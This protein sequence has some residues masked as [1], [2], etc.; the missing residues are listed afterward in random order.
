MNNTLEYSV[1][2]IY[3]ILLIVI[4]LIFRSFNRNVSDYFRGGSRG[5]WWLVGVSSFIAGISAYTFT[6]AAGAVYDA[7]WS[8]LVIYI[9]GAS[10]FMINYFYF[11]SRF[12]QLRKTTGQE[13]I[14][15]RFNQSTEQLYAWISFPSGILGSAMLLYSLAIFISAIFGFNIQLLIIAVGVVVICY[16]IIGG[17]WAIMAT[18][19][20]QCLIVMGLSLLVGIL[21][22]M[23]LNGFSGLLAHIDN[24]GL[25]AD[26]AI[27]NSPERFK[28]SFTYFWAGAMFLNISLA[29]NSLGAASRYFS[30]KDGKEAKK[31]ALLSCVLM[32]GGC[33]IWFLPPMT[34][35]IL[36]SDTVVKMTQLS[37]PKEAAFA[38]TCMKLLP[39]GMIG[40]MAV[41]MFAASISSLDTG[42]NGCS[43]VF[44]MNIYPVLAKL[45][46][47]RKLSESTMLKLSRLFTFLFGMLCIVVA[48]LFS[49]KS[50]LSLFDLMLMIF[51]LIGTPM[52]VPLLWGMIIRRCPQ[53]AAL[54]SII[55]GFSVSTIAF[56]SPDLFD[57]Q[58]SF[59]WQITGVYLGGS[60]GFLISL[61]WVGRNS[62]EYDRQVDDFFELMNKPVDFEKEIG[63]ANDNRQLKIIGVVSMVVGLL[64]ALLAIPA[65]NT[66]GVAC[67]LFLTLFMLSC[68]GLMYYVGTREKKVKSNITKK[69]LR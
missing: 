35:R 43:S 61:F 2:G 48:L 26:Y 11:A 31:A 40:L 28:G 36:Y 37:N 5:T 51:A 25:T 15:D 60:L 46:K 8:V 52:T 30:V 10:G 17:R 4:G 59:A 54:S 6:G 14:R 24:C 68:G 69:V 39:P 16:S 55:C 3:L 19:F 44:I 21:C 7:G 53:W 32:L 9:G 18:D 63:K 33:I 23:K 65:K 64:I 49:L 42:L 67:P 29:N 38:V 57:C 1:I 45:F 56:F 41:A 22:L 13:V 27:I 12:R 58:W 34:A 66:F 62:K 20:I 50:K 47:I